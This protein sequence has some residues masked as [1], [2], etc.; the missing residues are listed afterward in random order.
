MKKTEPSLLENEMQ[1]LQAIWEAHNQ[2]SPLVLEKLTSP[3]VGEQ[4]LKIYI[5]T[6]ST[7]GQSHAEQRGDY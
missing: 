6:T 7:G 4:E 2:I 5:S 3:E 1:K